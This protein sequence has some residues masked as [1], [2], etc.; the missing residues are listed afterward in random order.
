M[1]RCMKT[2]FR[3]SKETIDRL[4]ECNR[5]SGEVWNRCLDLAKETHLKTG[6][7]ITKSEL[8]KGTK[9]TFPIHSQSVQAVCHKYLFARDSARKARK[10]GHPNKYPYKRK[11]HFNTK[12][13]NNGFKVFE[14]GKIQLSMGK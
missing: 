5:V 1:I 6:K 11:N 10:A 4:F 3:A 9:G 14:N 13:A 2:S 7:W 8:Q 12:W